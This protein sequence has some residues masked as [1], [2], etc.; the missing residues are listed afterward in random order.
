[1]TSHRTAHLSAEQLEALHVRA[2]RRVRLQATDSAD[3]IAL[4]DMLGL[5][6]EGRPEFRD[7]LGRVR[8]P[9][10]VNGLDPGFWWGGMLA[11][12]PALLSS[13]TSP[14]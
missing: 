6:P 5:L 14:P 3:A 1:M 13:E 11:P 10:S 7:E 4:L 8:H 9:A 12:V 2:R